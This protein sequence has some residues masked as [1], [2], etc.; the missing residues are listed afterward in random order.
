[1]RSVRQRGET[2]SD[3]SSLLAPRC[4]DAFDAGERSRGV[5][6]FSE[7]RV[8]LGPVDENGVLARVRGSRSAPYAVLVDWGDA[9]WGDGLTVACDC[10]RFED[11]SLCKHLWATLLALDGAGEG[12]W[13]PGKGKLELHLDYGNE[14]GVEAEEIEEEVECDSEPFPGELA[15]LRDFEEVAVGAAA[16][17]DELPGEDL[18]E[19]D[20]DE[21][22]DYDDTPRWDS[23]PWHSGPRRERPLR[24]QDDVESKQRWQQQLDVLDY[25]LDQV[26]P[27]GRAGRWG[28]PGAGPG[29][30]SALD[31]IRATRRREIW[32]EIN[33][34]VSAARGRLVIDLYQRRERKDGAL[35]QIK[36]LALDD[37]ALAELGD[38]RERELARLALAMPPE[39]GPWSYGSPSGNAFTTHKGGSHVRPPV[40]RFSV[41]GPLYEV[42]LPRLAAAGHL[43]WWE[44]KDG[45]P[46]NEVRLR[47][48]E[49]L[50][51]RLALRLEKTT[52]SA[53]DTYRLTGE[54]VRQITAA[55]S[56]DSPDGAGE[57]DETAASGASAGAD[58]P[59]GQQEPTGRTERVALKTPTLLLAEGLALS[60]DRLARLDAH[61]EFPWIV[62]LR[63]EGSIDIPAEDLPAALEELFRL[64][65]VPS[66]ELPD[67]L[68]IEHQR[69]APQPRLSLWAPDRRDLERDLEADLAFG[70][71][72]LWVAAEDPR[73][74]VVD[75]EDGSLLLRDREAE[76]RALGLLAE[77][78]ISMVSVEDGAGGPGGSADFLLVPRTGVAHIVGRLLAEGWRVEAEGEWVRPAGAVRAAID[79]VSGSGMDWFELRGEI[80]FGDQSAQLGDILAA[81]RRGQELVEL[82][83]GSRGMLPRAWVERLARLAELVPEDGE[84]DAD[85][86]GEGVRFLPSQALLLD[87]LMAGATDVEVD[88][89]FA[90]LRQ[91]LR[92]VHQVEPEEAPDGFRGE[93]RGYQKDG[94]GWLTLLGELGLGGCLADDMGLGKTIQVLALIEK[95]RL[96]SAGDG[97][98]RPSLVVAPRSLIYN[99]LDEAR[100]F[101]PELTAL[102]YTGTGREALRERFAEHDLVITTYGTLRRDI[103]ELSKIVFDYAI[104]DE[105]QAIKNAESLTAKAARSLRAE[106][107]LA[108]T[109]TPVE[110]H[111]GELGS[112][113]EYLN[114]GMLGR[115]SALGDLLA[116]WAATSASKAIAPDADELAGLARALGP[117]ILRR[118]KEE[119]LPELPP[120]TEQ[121][122]FVTLGPAQRSLYEQLKAHFREQLTQRIEE[123]GLNRSRM[124]VLEALLRLRQAACHPELLGAE[125]ELEGDDGN[126]AGGTGSAKLDTLFE[127]LDEVLDEGHKALVFSQFTK[128]LGLVRERLDERGVVYEYLDGQT[129]DRKARVERFQ[130][131][132]DCRLFL[133]SL[134]AGGTGLNL[135]AADYVFLLDPW[136]NPAVE[137]QAVDRAHRIGQDR[138]VIAYRLIAKETVEEKILALQETKRDLADAVLSA[139]GSALTKLSAED[140][141]LLLS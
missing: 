120:K 83:D 34:S 60:G 36:P 103:E 133:I 11:G 138:P 20:D 41:P 55:P 22:D 73:S 79:F 45:R 53:S 40:G 32:Y 141:E 52:G 23:R 15:L 110:N 96:L 51:W 131:D 27:V 25:A 140:L 98:K 130:G 12:R 99:W 88:T 3:R 85:A 43:S 1:M 126:G 125:L 26:G 24:G 136:W 137:A 49:G 6:Y 64:P 58:S 108:L 75:R 78:G 107:R 92:T 67:D 44:G 115:S 46:G 18:G 42:V 89:R 100:R 56:G 59:A 29:G 106:H 117:F 105:A 116:P 31:S 30:T 104:L 13:V 119:V 5:S 19:L 47:W 33:R 10:P 109:G 112:L 61:A 71:H 93:L 77:L 68:P 57:D 87:S 38:H 7:G 84:V 134:K 111:L 21:E 2:P 69:P 62:L 74:A 81:V 28:R 39:H 16:A 37:A 114:P 139:G 102:D 17:D 118:T 70:Y 95:R 76:A 135:T 113:F 80:A 48:D 101:T 35:G 97:P 129:R 122:L 82:G 8:R 63:R 121:T 4:A 90:D 86:E 127:Q 50:P 54:L 123:Y 14:F 72:D 66:L 91:R 128:L 132:P 9:E 94:L 65:A 124:H